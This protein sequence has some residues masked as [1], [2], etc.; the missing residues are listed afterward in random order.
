M[1]P[2]LNKFENKDSNVSIENH[3]DGKDVWFKAY[4]VAKALGY[5]RPGKAI[6]DDID[7]DNKTKYEKFKDD[8]EGFIKNFQL[9]TNLINE[10]GVKQLVLKS[11]IPKAA[12]IAK[13]FDICI[14]EIALYKKQE[15]IECVM[16]AF[17]G[18]NMIFQRTISKHSIDLYF[19][20]HK[21][22]IE[23]DEFGHKDRNLK[24]EI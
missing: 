23:C 10:N 16:K 9:H 1:S 17:R 24:K 15:T 7:G 8:A 5:K 12:D 11:R 22:A 4:D 13:I 3:T 6:I 20:D 19:P 14:C 2:K 18:E 21:L